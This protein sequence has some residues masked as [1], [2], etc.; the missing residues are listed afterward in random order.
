MT[1]R[2]DRYSGILLATL[3]LSV[4]ALPSW[5]SSD[6]VRK[7]SE[8]NVGKDKLA[9]QGYDPVAYFPEGGG[10]P[11]KGDPAIV[12]EYAGALYRFAKAAHRE[13]FLA[14]PARYEPAHGGWCSYAMLQ[15]DK[16]QVDPTSFIVKDDRLFLFY[17]GF[18]GNTRVKWLKGDHATEATAADAMWKTISGESARTAGEIR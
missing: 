11:I 12:T 10:V 3:L 2:L 7:V 9:V 15:G 5:A 6:A 16:V 4:I 8:W 13:K 17:N 1:R 18:L 14:N